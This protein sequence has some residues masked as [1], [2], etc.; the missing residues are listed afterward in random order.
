MIN[1][2]DL[3]RNQETIQVEIYQLLVDLLRESWTRFSRPKVR[4]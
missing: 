1:S 3:N 2:D 4:I